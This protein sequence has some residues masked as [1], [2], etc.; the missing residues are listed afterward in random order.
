MDVDVPE[1]DLL[2][3]A[4]R[5]SPGW[6]SLIYRSAKIQKQIWAQP[7]G[8]AAISPTG[9]EDD[10][11]SFFYGAP[12]YPCTTLMNPLFTAQ[13]CS[14]GY[15]YISQDFAVRMKPME[16]HGGKSTEYLEFRTNL[17]MPAPGIYERFKAHD[18]AT[19]FCVPTWRKM[20]LS[21]PP[22]T[23][24]MLM[25]EHYYKAPP[26]LSMI[27]KVI[28]RD[29]DGVT[30]GLVYDMLAT[31]MPAFGAS[32]E[33]PNKKC[34]SV[35]AHVCWFENKDEVIKD[36]DSRDKSSKFSKNYGIQDSG[37]GGGDSGGD[38]V[39]DEGSIVH[40]S[41]GNG[42]GGRFRYRQTRQC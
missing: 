29:N 7:M 26:D 6:K 32:L 27:F 33:D 10:D 20:Y 11:A 1:R 13:D 38:G 2:F 21:Q 24:M 36:E 19:S 18:D 17:M 3:N 25:V 22:V 8:Q 4:Q 14:S 37:S 15:R 31:T 40:D 42:I 9:F 41:D 39:G 35:H 23:T 5:V 30:M 34:K 28:I 12:V 16:M